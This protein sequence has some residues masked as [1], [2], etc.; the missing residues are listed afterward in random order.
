MKKMFLLLTLMFVVL[1]SSKSAYSIPCDEGCTNPWSTV[2]LFPIGEN[3]TGDCSFMIYY[4]TRQCPGGVPQIRLHHI[5]FVQGSNCQFLNTE[6]IIAEAV[7]TL[8]ANVPDIF[9]DPFQ[10]SYKIY[11]PSCMQ[12]NAYNNINHLEACP[13]SE[14]CV[15]S[16]N[17]AL[18]N[19]YVN[20]LSQTADAL[21]T[22]CPGLVGG[23]I[24]HCSNL[25]VPLNTP[26]NP[27]GSGLYGPRCTYSNCGTNPWISETDVYNWLGCS[28][29]INYFYRFV[30]NCGL[31]VIELQ[32]SSVQVISGTMDII[33]ILQY[34]YK[35]LIRTVATNYPLCRGLKAKIYVSPCWTHIRDNNTSNII[36]V[37]T[38]NDIGGCCSE[39][40][41]MPVYGDLTYLR[42]TYN[43][44]IYP[45]SNPSCN[46]NFLC[47]YYCADIL[48][49]LFDEIYLPKISSNDFI[50][51]KVI[52]LNESVN[53]QPNPNKG[54]L[55]LL[56]ES[57]F[58][59]NFELYIYDN[60]S[61]EIFFKNYSKQK[62]EIRINL[63]LNNFTDGMYYF[64]IVQQDKESKGKF[65]IN[66]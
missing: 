54:N 59:G 3:M 18:I 11:V 1:L 17:S 37:H 33:N 50:G 16:Y 5:E 25:T 65:I 51:E 30:N 43:E 23:C 29:R 60:N 34:S 13:N 14:C 24:G 26:L 22:D 27:N 12:I 45:D 61:K 15:Y 40:V 21:N 44:N 8:N 53:I 49:F 47:E 42:R 2:Q 7:K 19:G 56:Y 62:G 28:F 39:E 6:N 10:A 63:N 57:N 36:E 58:D 52:L 41:E 20:V 66:K 64:R 32:L 31:I 48:F 55:D 4:Q 9:G 46:G 35:H 38:C